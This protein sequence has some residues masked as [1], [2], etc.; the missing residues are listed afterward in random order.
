MNV[1]KD[2]DINPKIQWV[3]SR[4]LQ[5]WI[6]W[7][8]FY[9]VNRQELSQKLVKS[10]AKMF[11]PSSWVTNLKKFHRRVVMSMVNATRNM[12]NFH[13]ENSDDEFDPKEMV[14]LQQ[15]ELMKHIHKWLMKKTK[16]LIADAKVSKC[17]GLFSPWRLK[18]KFR[19]K[20][21]TQKPL[22]PHIK[23]R[24]LSP[25]TGIA[26]IDLL[27][28]SNNIKLSENKRRIYLTNN[29]VEN[30]KSYRKDNIRNADWDSLISKIKYDKRLKL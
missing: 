12:K 7:T 3:H 5:D 13:S 19:N 11:S 9:D 25:L 22:C 16:K 18:R 17:G 21:L 23:A 28:P 10:R 29:P 15:Y 6:L 30:F 24:N 26:K 20:N 14:D 27:S 4:S 8:R 2:K 1:L